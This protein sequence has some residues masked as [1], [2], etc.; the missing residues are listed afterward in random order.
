MIKDVI[1]TVGV[2]GGDARIF[3]MHIPL[4]KE[5]DIYDI[6]KELIKSY[7]PFFDRLI[8]AK[9]SGFESSPPKDLVELDVLLDNYNEEYGI[10]EQEISEEIV[11]R[12]SHLFLEQLDWEETKAL[13]SYSIRAEVIARLLRQK[14]YH[15]AN[16]FENNYYGNDS[17]VSDS[18]VK[19]VMDRFPCPSIP[20]TRLVELRDDL[21][22]VRRR[23][24]FRLWLRKMAQNKKPN[25]ILE[26]FQELLYQYE[27]YMN[28]QRIKYNVGQAQL[29]FTTIAEIGENLVR[30]KFSKVVRI[31]FEIKKQDIKLT[32]AELSAPGREISFIAKLRDE[33]S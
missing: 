19:L 16:T 32:E 27:E 29:I 17:G 11:L 2:L 33:E 15:A 13:Q 1:S 10:S 28:L 20:I 21:E 6:D 18:L 24:A 7:I 4:V 12:A 9:E 8:L 26:E 23:H 30:L 5:S 22:M 31:I 14:G 3:K 25:E